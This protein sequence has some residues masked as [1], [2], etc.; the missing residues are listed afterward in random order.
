MDAGA[1][2]MIFHNLRNPRVNERGGE[3]GHSWNLE[4][5]GN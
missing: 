1:L 4:G 2:A 3:P 5:I